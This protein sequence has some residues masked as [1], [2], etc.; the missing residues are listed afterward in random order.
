MNEARRMEGGAND[1]GEEGGARKEKNGRQAVGFG[2]KRL[3]NEGG[4]GMAK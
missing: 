1:F 2:E 3:L 4:N